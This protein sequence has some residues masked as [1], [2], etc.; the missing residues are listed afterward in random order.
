MGSEM[1]IRDR[2]EGGRRLRWTAKRVMDVAQ[3]L[4]E[5]GYITYM[6]T[7]GVQI[8]GEAIAACRNT[9]SGQYGAAYLPEEARAYRSTAKNAQE[10]HEAI[11]PTDVTRLP[12][13]IAPYLDKDQLRLYELIWKRTIEI[14]MANALMERETVDISAADIS[15]M[16]RA[17]GSITLF[18]GFLKVYQEGRDDQPGND[19]DRSLPNVSKGQSLTKGAVSP[20]QHFTEPAPRCSEATLVKRLEELGIGRPSTYASTVSYTHLTL[21][22]KA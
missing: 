11:R 12:S 10:A 8:A 7:D 9:I 21:P 20:N 14:K 1:C 15:C 6:R 2:Q 4:Y 3:R 22:T 13:Q 5:G 19:E 17:T 16:L 18:D